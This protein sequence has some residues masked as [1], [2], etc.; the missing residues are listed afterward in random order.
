MLNSWMNHSFESDCFN[1]SF[2]LVY[3]LNITTALTNIKASLTSVFH[4]EKKKKKKKIFGLEQ[5][6]GV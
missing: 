6:E 4:F 1:E 5:H 2:D 3:K